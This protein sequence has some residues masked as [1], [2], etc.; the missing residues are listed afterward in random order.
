MYVLVNG[1]WTIFDLVASP[2]YSVDYGAPWNDYGGRRVNLTIMP[3][4]SLVSSDYDAMMVAGELA[5]RCPLDWQA[6]APTLIC[7][8]VSTIPI[9][10]NT[11]SIFS[12]IF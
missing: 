9:Y 11:S 7:S 6:G 10:S 5:D 8:H 4:W 12:N 1:D 3:W 2:L